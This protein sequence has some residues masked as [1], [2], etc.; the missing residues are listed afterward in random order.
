MRKGS[1]IMNRLVIGI[2]VVCLVLGSAT[3]AFAVPPS[4][5]VR[6]E[7][8]E[9]LTGQCCF[10]WGETVTVTE[11]KLLV[12]VV[13]TFSTDFVATGLIQ[14]GVAI[15]GHPCLN[16]DDIAD[17]TPADGTSN[18]RTYQFIL[19]PDDGL[20]KGSN[21]ITLCGGGLEANDSITLGFSTLAVRISK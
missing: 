19:F 12:P 2:A 3:A 8:N 14:V 20:M 9:T 15:N 4:E 18:S 6:R 17:S 1:E 10:S 21:T 13:V 16:N 7:T 5:V 11:P